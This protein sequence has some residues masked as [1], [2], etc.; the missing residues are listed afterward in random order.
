MPT[1][2][3]GSTRP[4]RAAQKAVDAE[5][6]PLAAQ[7][8]QKSP[9]RAG[10]RADLRTWSMPSGRPVAHAHRGAL[11]GVPAGDAVTREVFSYDGIGRRDPF[12]SL[13]LTDDLRPL[14]ADLRLVGILYEASG[15]RTVAVMRDLQTNAQYRV[16]EW[17]V[18]RPYARRPDPPRAVIVHD[19][20]VRTQPSGLAGLVDTL[21]GE[22]LM[23]PVLAV[24]VAASLAL[25]PDRRAGCSP[26]R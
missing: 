12:F 11:D 21:K 14:L 4:K 23:K 18:A 1:P 20:R 15:R 8:G 24:I 2:Q 7:T 25:G 26:P 5:N 13:I 3:H 22:E 6:A 19:R 9:S 17:S 16:N 10:R